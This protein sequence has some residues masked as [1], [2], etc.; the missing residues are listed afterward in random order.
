MLLATLSLLPLSAATGAPDGGCGRRIFSAS[1]F[2][3][4]FTHG[5]SVSTPP[6]SGAWTTLQGLPADT[7]HYGPGLSVA[8]FGRLLVSGTRPVL[9]LRPDR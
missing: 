8:G 7:G 5:Y 2:Y 4:F 9:P 6:A 3:F 1:V